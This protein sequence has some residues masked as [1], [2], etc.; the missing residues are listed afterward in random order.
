MMLSMCIVTV[1]SLYINA[2]PNKELADYGFSEHMKDLVPII[3]L[4]VIMG[5]AVS[6]A[7]ILPLSDIPRLIL[8]VLVGV[9]VYAAGSYV[10]RLESFEYIKE[11]VFGLLRKNKS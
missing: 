5:A 6:A 11:F 7:G 4:N 2:R 3:L 1:I 8:Q 9:V 10:L